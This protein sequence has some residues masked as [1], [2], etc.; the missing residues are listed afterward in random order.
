MA[1]KILV[2]GDTIIDETINTKC[3]GISLESPTM[4]TEYV[5]SSI[6]YGGASNIA[7]NISHLGSNTEFITIG[8]DLDIPG[9][10][11]IYVHGVPHKKTRIWCSNGD[12]E[13]KMLQVNHV[14]RVTEVNHDF[15]LNAISDQDVVVVADYRKGLFDSSLISNII[16]WCSDLEIQCICSSQISDTT[17]DYSIFLNADFVIMNNNEYE[18]FKAATLYNCQCIVTMGK[19]G[20]YSYTNSGEYKVHS[21]GYQITPIDTT[22]AGDCFVAAFAHSDNSDIRGRMDFANK[23]AALSTTVKGTDIYE[24]DK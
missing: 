14:G 6:S 13:Y 19:S 10:D 23:Y 1:K 15:I 7:K 2:I 17:Y 4:K 21:S 20:S 18:T 5:S 12:S 24:S 11:V 16:A 9:V 3:V 22:G 8:S